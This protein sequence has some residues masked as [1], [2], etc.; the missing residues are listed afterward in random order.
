MLMKLGVNSPCP[1]GSKKKYKKCCQIYHKGALAKDAL[2]LMKSRYSA[3]AAG[4]IDYIIKTA[5]SQDDRAE[6]EAFSRGCE[7]LKLT[8]LEY[9][10]NTVTFHATIRCGEQDASF[11][12]KSYFV[13]KEGRWLYER[14]EILD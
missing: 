6:L 5:L 7:F 10:E 1:C 4:E 12:E 2:T 11:S 9:D 13:Q 3:F 8:I 14:G